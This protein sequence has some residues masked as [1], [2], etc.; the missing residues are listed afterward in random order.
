[1][2]IT[3]ANGEEIIPMGA[4]DGCKSLENVNLP[5]SLKTI[6]ERAFYET[7]IKTLRLGNSVQTIGSQAFA[8]SA[9]EEL[10]IS[11]AVTNIANDAFISTGNLETIEV[12]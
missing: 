2:G 8:K 1:M 12:N 9:I 4:F 10:Y 5:S 7:S 11:A 3:I 6:S